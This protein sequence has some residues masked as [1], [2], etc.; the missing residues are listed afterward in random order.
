MSDNLKILIIPHLRKYS[1]MRKFYIFLYYI[2]IYIHT[3]TYIIVQSTQH[4]CI[5]Y[6][7]RSKQHISTYKVII[8]LAKNYETLTKSKHVSLTFAYTTQLC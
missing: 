4:T 7:Q 5:L 3:H 1:K 8:R 6:R 2:Y